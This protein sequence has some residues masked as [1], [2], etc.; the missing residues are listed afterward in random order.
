MTVRGPLA[1]PKVRPDIGG[2][3]ESAAKQQLRKE[4]DKVEKKLKDKVEDALKDL[5][6]Q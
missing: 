4:G 5:L 6:G 3:L 2:L 1:D